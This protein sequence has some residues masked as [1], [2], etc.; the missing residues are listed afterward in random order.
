MPKSQLKRPPRAQG[1]LFA[2]N[3]PVES[4]SLSVTAR[5]SQ[6]AR[7]AR[8]APQLDNEALAAPAAPFLKWVGGKG[9]LLSQLLPLMPKRGPFSRYFEPFVGGGAVFFALAPR[10]ATLSDL[11]PDLVNCYQVI[12]TQV[13]ALIA[14]LGKHVYEKEYY[15]QV[16]AQDAGELNPVARAA[17]FIYLNKTCFNGLHRVNRAG[18]FNVP[19]GRY[20]NPTICDS[21][22]LRAVSRIL[23]GTDI[24]CSGYEHVLDLARPGDFV[25]FDPPYAPISATSSFTAYTNSTFGAKEQT[26][27]RD[28]FKALDRK[29]VKV[30]LSNSNAGFISELYRDFEITEVYATRS[31][32]R[33]A[34]GRGPIPELVIRNYT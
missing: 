29:G 14:E 1:D 13:D 7:L 23:Q 3:D 30:M 33:D 22:R 20:T 27:L 26:D 19:F 24:R 18:K 28:T 8:L 17:R 6:S 2:A 25:Y 34:S 15:Y 10:L 21:P 9:Q 4:G 12:K 16:R 11:N 5:R 32:N 31:I